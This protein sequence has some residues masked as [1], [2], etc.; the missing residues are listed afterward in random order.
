MPTPSLFHAD[1]IRRYDKSGPRYT[2]YPPATE[3]HD[4][5]GETDFRE[6]ARQSNEDPIPKPLSLYLHIPFCSSICYYCAC[7]KVITK[8]QEKAEPYLRNLHREIELQGK[9]FDSDR[10][11]RQMH[12][13]GGTPGFLTREQTHDLVQCIARNFRLSDDSG[14]DYSIE[15]D[16]RVMRSGDVAQLRRLGFNRI[17]LGVQDFDAEVQQAVNRVQSVES[18]AAVIDEARHHGIR[19]INLDLIYGLPKQSLGSFASTLGNVV[20]LD[21]DRIAIYNYAHLPHRFPPQRR[22]DAA[23]LP[24]AEEK[25]EILRYAVEFLGEM[26]YVYIGMDHFAKPDDELAVAQRSG[27]LQRNFQGYS[28]H[29]SCDS[30]GLGVSAIS[31]VND[32]FSQNC[33]GL[34]DYHN[35]LEQGR[36]PLVRGYQSNSDDLIRRDIIQALACHG[37]LDIA[38]LEKR[39]DIEF[40]SYFADEIE[41]LLEMQADGLLEYDPSWIRLC[42]PGR[43]LVRNICMAFDRYLQRERVTP[44][45]SRTL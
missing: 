22:I 5:I 24:D 23:E 6:W 19:S 30:I 9:L 41:R 42:E 35:A 3:F 25:L 33:L 38:S 45:F 1:L 37:E 28:T 43:L 20:A 44:M 11:V 26:G 7:N 21:P 2:S 16:P 10:E 34:E 27:G 29:A 4:R 14:R 17:S 36:L 13:G 8:R 39:W 15:I 12:W 18:T 40:S 31:M 32:H